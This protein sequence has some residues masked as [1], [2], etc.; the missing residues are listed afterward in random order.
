MEGENRGGE[1]V[2]DFLLLGVE[3]RALCDVAVAV[4]TEDVEG[5]FE[6]DDLFVGAHAGGLFAVE[7]ITSCEPFKFGGDITSGLQVSERGMKGQRRTHPMLK[8]C[9]LTEGGLKRR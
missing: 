1:V 8:P 4:G 9:I 2:A 7:F 3:T 5:H 6:T